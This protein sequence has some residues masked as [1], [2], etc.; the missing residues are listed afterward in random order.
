MVGNVILRF[1]FYDV[2]FIWCVGGGEWG[3]V[4]GFECM[5]MRLRVILRSLFLLNY[6]LLVLNLGC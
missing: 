3:G 4:G 5:G 2:F 6:R 1:F